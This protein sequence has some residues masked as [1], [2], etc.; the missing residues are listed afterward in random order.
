[1]VRCEKCGKE[2]NCLMLS[3]F[4]HDGAD[5]DYA[6]PIR[7][8]EEDAVCVE[9]SPAWTG[10]ELSEEEQM[11]TIHCPYCG[12]FPF[13][14]QEVKTQTIVKVVCFKSGPYTEDWGEG[15]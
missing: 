4:G 13:A 1:M 2:M 3:V 8:V 12:E 6:I 7:E 9:V 11:E 10:N 14:H 15:E 5:S